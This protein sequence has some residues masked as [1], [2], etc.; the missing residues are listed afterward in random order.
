MSNVMDGIA[1]KGRNLGTNAWLIVLAIALVVFGANTGYATW[2]AARLG[3]AST[4][5]SSLQV[6]SQKL[7]NQGREAV[8]G[9]PEAFKAFKATKA[10]VDGDIQQLNSNYGDT[11]GV[12]GP[13]RTVSDTWTPLEKSAQQ[14]IGSEAAVRLALGRR[15]LRATGLRQRLGAD[16]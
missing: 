11:T 7:T 16:R 4:S 6:N 9:K 2:K 14:V 5:A 1:G 8:E 10:Q 3:G 15:A 13:I 12:A